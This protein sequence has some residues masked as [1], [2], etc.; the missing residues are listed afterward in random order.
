MYVILAYDI[1]SDRRRGRL[2]R[3][4]RGWLEPVQK[5]VFEGELPARELPRLQAVVRHHIDEREDDVRIYLLCGGC[6]SSTLLLGR[7][8]RPPDPRD[9]I[10]V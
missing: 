3:R 5:S 8:R 9:P 10:I 4:L 1:P 2:H 7:A 6:A